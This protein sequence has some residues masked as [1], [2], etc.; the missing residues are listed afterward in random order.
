MFELLQ[1]DAK[2]EFDPNRPIGTAPLIVAAPAQ[3]LVKPLRLL[4]VPRWQLGRVLEDIAQHRDPF[5]ELGH[6]LHAAFV[7]ELRLR[8]THHPAHSRPRDRKRPARSP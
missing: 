7:F 1:V 3:L 2:V 8:A 4:P 5:P 6:Q